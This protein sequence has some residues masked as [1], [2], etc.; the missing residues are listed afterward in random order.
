[1][2]LSLLNHLFWEVPGARIAFV[3]ADCAVL[4]AFHFID[5]GVKEE[6]QTRE[7]KT[8]QVLDQAN[9]T[10]KE[11]KSGIKTAQKYQVR[12]EKRTTKHQMRISKRPQN[13]HQ[14]SKHA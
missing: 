11:E 7:I 12:N 6:A 14:P 10:N 8:R 5:K 2:A 3:V 13:I 4:A 1:M 9:K